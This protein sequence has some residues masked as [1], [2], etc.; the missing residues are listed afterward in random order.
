MSVKKKVKRLDARGAFCPVPTVRVSLALEKM[1]AGEVLDLLADDPT[2]RR[3]LVGWC[4]EF[5]HRVLGIFELRKGFRVRI[6]KH[7]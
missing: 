4:G 2:T 1:G 6:Q 7:S 3:D 5:G